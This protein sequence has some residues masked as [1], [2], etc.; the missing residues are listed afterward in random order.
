MSL[1]QYSIVLNTT[2]QHG[3][4]SWFHCHLFYELVSC[5]HFLSSCMYH[6]VSIILC[7][8]ILTCKQSGNLQTEW[9]QKIWR[10]N[11]QFAPIIPIGAKSIGAKVSDWRQSAPIGG[12]FPS[13]QQRYQ[14]PIGGSANHRQLLAVEQD[15]RSPIGANRRQSAP[16]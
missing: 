2:N 11:F 6:L 12:W 15:W 9:R 4:W 8:V 5:Y 16:N 10:Q 1:S 13:F 7:L 14:T 3:L